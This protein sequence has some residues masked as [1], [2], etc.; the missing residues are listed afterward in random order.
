MIPAR[1]DKKF[2][3]ELTP[4]TLMNKSNNWVFRDSNFQNISG[5]FSTTIKLVIS[6]L[7]RGLCIVKDYLIYHFKRNILNRL[8]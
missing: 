2:E 7:N 8:M 3:R 1:T 5:K 4:K 6:S